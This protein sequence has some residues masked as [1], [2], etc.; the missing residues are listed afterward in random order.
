VAERQ[1]PVLVY[2]RI[3]A[4]LRNSRWLVAAVPLLMLPFGAGLAQY[5][6]PWVLMFLVPVIASGPEWFADP[7]RTLRF[8]ELVAGLSLAIVVVA[9]TASALALVWLYTSLARRPVSTPISRDQ[10]P[11]LW[12][13]VENLS[14][15][16]GLPQPSLYVIDSPVP[17]AFTTGRDPQHASIAVT[18]GLLSLLDRR[19]LAAVIGHEL[20]HIGNH[21]ISLGTT[22]AGV[23]GA[24]RL[25]L[26]CVTR[27]AKVLA[28]IHPLLGVV[29]SC[30]S[31]F[32]LLAIV[33]LGIVSLI[34]PEDLSDGPAWVTWWKLAAIVAP[35]YVLFVAPGIASF[36][37]QAISRQR[38][39]LADADAVVL[40]RDPEG[41]ALA[42][43][44]IGAWTGAALDTQPAVAH[45][46]IADPLGANAAWWDRIFPCHPPI[47]ARIDLLSRMSGSGVSATA[48]EQAR[49]AGSES[50]ERE[51]A[52]QMPDD[53]GS[54]R[55]DA[56]F[57]RMDEPADYD[58][59]AD[60]GEPDGEAVASSP[61]T[62]PLYEKP[63]GW[64]TVLRELPLDALLS[65]GPTEGGFVQVTTADNIVGYIP[66]ITRTRN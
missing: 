10:E 28:R 31:L 8:E 42:L 64:S 52:K 36:I 54:E 7:V 57:N 11:D 51:S 50:A 66:V 46:Y 6:M 55:R 29:F 19:E 16:A 24:A 43:A 59:T 37:R 34:S 48:L 23:V 17:N 44:K 9:V 41:L 5:L 53:G 32:M 14:I 21:D 22:V 61:A 35:P 38:E 40:T 12:R 60:Y 63:D 3:Q 25:P 20:S 65:F 13:V 27:F 56:S 4:N 47:K 58:E 15:G 33:G 26:A 62:I 18:R 2:N 1:E 45:L 30:V 39:F 49:I